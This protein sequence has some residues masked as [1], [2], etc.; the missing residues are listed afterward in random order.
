MKMGVR[1]SIDGNIPVFEDVVVE[2]IGIMKK[3]RYG[4]VVEYFDKPKKIV[5][6]PSCGKELKDLNALKKHYADEHL[7][8]E[9]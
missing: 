1:K 7:A 8:G 9:E 2:Q 6:C 5:L 3:G 4:T